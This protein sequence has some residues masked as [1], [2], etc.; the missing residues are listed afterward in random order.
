MKVWATE[1]LLAN[2]RTTATHACGVATDLHH[3]IVPV[4]KTITRLIKGQEI[5]R[6]SFS[7][8]WK[9]SSYTRSMDTGQYGTARHRTARSLG[10]LKRSS[11]GIHQQ[12][13]NWKKTATSVPAGRMNV[14]ASYKICIFQLR[15]QPDVIPPNT[16]FRIKAAA[17]WCWRFIFSRQR[18]KSGP[19]IN[20]L[21]ASTC[22][23]WVRSSLASR[24]QFRQY[25]VELPS[26]KIRCMQ[27]QVCH[28]SPNAHPG[29]WLV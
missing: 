26:V 3:S 21:S 11:Q 28:V 12:P 5:W 22:T 19:R 16:R 8:N 25:H 9:F 20:P 4:V 17:M 2:G 15:S 24:H 23:T 7:H 27:S 13:P 29:A 14:G 18:H 1:D 6:S 10:Q